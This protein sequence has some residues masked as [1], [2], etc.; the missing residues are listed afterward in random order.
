MKNKDVSEDPVIRRFLLLL[1][2]IRK[3]IKSVYLFGSRSRDD[4]RPDSDY[5]ILIVLE[6]KERTCSK[7]RN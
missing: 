3:E 5:D 1:K 6:R 2:P 7:G 4:W